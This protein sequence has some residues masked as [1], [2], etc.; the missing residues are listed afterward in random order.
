M[1]STFF[2]VCPCLFLKEWITGEPRWAGG[3]RNQGFLLP[4]WISRLPGGIVYLK[5]RQKLRLPNPWSILTSNVFSLPSCQFLSLSSQTVSRLFVS[6]DFSLRTTGYIPTCALMGMMM[7]EAAA[8]AS[9]KQA[10]GMLHQIT[11]Q[12]IVGG[13]PLHLQWTCVMELMHHGLLT[14][15]QEWGDIFSSALKMARWSSFHLLR[16]MGGN[17]M[18][19]NCSSL[20]YLDFV[21][22]VMKTEIYISI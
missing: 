11:M 15:K 9:S 16:N 18:S 13:L 21:Q 12:M 14:P 3:L 8:A 2:E 4:T 19:W 20:E 6:P 1:A 5:S 22:I 7:A 10:A 17:P